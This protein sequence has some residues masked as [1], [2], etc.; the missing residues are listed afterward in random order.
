[1]YT[2]Y[3]VYWPI[4]NSKHTISQF[5]EKN[6]LNHQ[7]HHEMQAYRHTAHSDSL[8]LELSA[9]ELPASLLKLSACHR[10]ASRSSEAHSHRCAWWEQHLACSG[11]GPESSYV[12]DTTSWT[13]H[14]A[15]TPEDDVPMLWNVQKASMIQICRSSQGGRSRI[16]FDMLTFV[17]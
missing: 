8:S 2:V 15:C 13:E 4:V 10:T 14:Q 9:S 11:W 17:Q 16:A 5:H 3:N 7:Y 1:M 12:I 6:S